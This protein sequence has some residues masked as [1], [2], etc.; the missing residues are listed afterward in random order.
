M[1][2][3]V[4]VLAKAPRLGRVKR[5]LARGVG[6]AEALRI[7]RACLAATLRRLGRDPRWDCVLA[8]A[9]D[10][11]L[12]GW[13][14]PCQTRPWQTRPQGHGD[15]GE[16]MLRGLAG[17]PGGRRR[18]PAVLVGGDIPEITAAAV[19]GAL[20]RLR[21]ADAVFGPS[22]DGG[23]WLI[24]FR[25]PPR[26]TDLLAGVR[27]SSP[28]ALADSRER[29]ARAGLTTELADPLADLDDR[30]SLRRWRRTARSRP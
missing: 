30:E 23:Y 9:P 8:V 19:A 11:A 25:R 26:R 1:R 2:P 12:T 6:E 5:R 13:P 28:Q 18:G 21:R 20:A 16:R 22:E 17:G 24:G 7:Y 14:R 15:L 4:V 29:L 3:R 27:W 10:R